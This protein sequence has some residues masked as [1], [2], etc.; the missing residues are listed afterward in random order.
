VR[1]RLFF[2]VLC[3]VELLTLVAQPA[4][5]DW[6][7]EM[8]IALARRE[9]TPANLAQAAAARQRIAARRQTDARVHGA[10]LLCNAAAIAFVGVKLV[11]KRAEP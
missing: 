2:V 3:L 8:A 11:K 6:G 10:L 4:R 7:A 5:H 1:W 9:P